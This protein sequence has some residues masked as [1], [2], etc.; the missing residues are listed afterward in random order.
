[1]IKKHKKYVKPRKAFES[2]RIAEENKLI[3]QYGLKNKREIWK[4][5]AKVTYFRHRAKALAKSAAEE[6]EVLFRKLK[7]IGLNTNSIADVL[8]LKVEDLLN[9]RLQTMVI[10]KRLASTPK[11]ARQMVTHR[12]ILINGKV[13]N[14]PGYIVSVAEEDSIVS[15]FIPKQPQKEAKRKQEEVKEE[16]KE[17]AEVK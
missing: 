7:A 4:V 17:A 2:A 12:K 1:M 13:V 6:Q 16:K 3:K 5:I 9:R 14:I 15:S 8:D 10:K 11:Q